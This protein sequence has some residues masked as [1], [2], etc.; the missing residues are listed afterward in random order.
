[1]LLGQLAIEFVPCASPRAS[2]IDQPIRRFSSAAWTP[3]IIRT[4]ISS[5]GRVPNSL[6]QPHWNCWRKNLAS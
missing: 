3:T 4:S 6:R 1:V 2:S 5:S